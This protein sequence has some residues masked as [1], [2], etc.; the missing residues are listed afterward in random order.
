MMTVS[1]ILMRM[2]AYPGNT[3]HD[4]EHL[5]KV[6]GYARLIGQR[7]GLDDHALYLL[8]V[9]AVVHDIACPAL[10]ERTGS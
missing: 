1:E 7:E 6:W 10:R 2:S 5:L 3:R 9:A 8:E 4:I